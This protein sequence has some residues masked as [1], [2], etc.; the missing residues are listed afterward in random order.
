MR[1]APMLMTMGNGMFGLFALWLILHGHPK[2]AM[3]AIVAGAILDLADGWTARRFGV[4]SSHGATADTVSDLVSF[5][6][7]PAAMIVTTGHGILRWTAA[8]VYLLG[9]VFRLIRFRLR[10]PE[11]REF[12]GM[13]SPMAA[14]AIVGLAVWSQ[15]RLPALPIVEVAAPI[16]A[17]LAVSLIPFPKTGHPAMKLMPRSLW[18]SLWIVHFVAF[19]FFPAEALWSFTVFYLFIG[20]TLMRRHRLVHPSAAGVEAQG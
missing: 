3:L 7:A 10:T 13:P 4:A 2:S 17:L 14:L 15:Q 6:V 12:Q 1:S 19:L 16:Y 11:A 18:W 8:G 5:G 9:I 20:P